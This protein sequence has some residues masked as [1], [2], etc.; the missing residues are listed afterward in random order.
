MP[1]AAETV[2]QTVRE[3]A[4]WL[5][6]VPNPGEA[7]VRQAIVLRLLQVC[8][9]DIWN[10]H[11]VIPEE[12][13]KAGFR[14]DLRLVAGEHEF[15]LEL[16]GM[17]VGIHEKDYSQVASYAGQKGIRWAMLTDGRVWVVLDEHL[18]GPYRERA[19]LKLE[20]DQ[21]DA[22]PFAEDVSLLFDEQR[23]R[24]G[25]F[26]EAVRQIRAQ[27]QRRQ[28]VAQ[29]LREY[30][31]VVEEVQREYG[32]STFEQAVAAAVKMG[33]ITEAG[34][35]SL[36]GL[37]GRP[38]RQ[39][40]ATSGAPEKPRLIRKD[41]KRKDSKRAAGKSPVV[42][43]YQVG[44]ATA[45]AWYVSASGRWIVKSGSTA[46]SEV[47]SYARGVANS[48]SNLL[49]AGKL[50]RLDDGRLRF[51]QDVEYPSPSAAAGDISGGAR[52]GWDVWKDEDGRSAQ[53]YRA[54]QS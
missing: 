9:F 50:E 16:K 4:G 45:R 49:A 33:L 35:E 44:E 40:E 20:L 27:Q 23:W 43:S 15:V 41:S 38:Y 51:T 29:M 18:K 37:S 22:A 13:D 19:V 17:N 52:N 3:I 48:R 32:I 11:I 6:T 26:E 42:F 12:T 39:D 54:Q 8:G 53:D 5:T 25:A 36:L 21:Q 24:S 1:Q 46:V 34:R 30:R 47:K 28:D 31:P 10:P 7:V 14:P 2:Q